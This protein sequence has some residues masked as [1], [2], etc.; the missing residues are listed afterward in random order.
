MRSLAWNKTMGRVSCTI[1]Q[2]PDLVIS[3][4]CETGGVNMPALKLFAHG[5]SKPGHEKEL[6]A[7]VQELLSAARREQ[8][9]FGDVEVYEAYETETAGEF[10]FHEAYATQEAFDRHSHLPDHLK[11]VAQLPEHLADG[12]TVWKV[13]SVGARE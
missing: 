11:I 12:Y 5:K 1:V 13:E 7:L 2:R 4:Q 9:E 8:A 10:I 6:R 3:S